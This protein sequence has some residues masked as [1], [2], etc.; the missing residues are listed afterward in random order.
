MS[1]FIHISNSHIWGERLLIAY[2]SILLQAAVTINIHIFFDK[3]ILIY[4]YFY[5]CCHHHRHQSQ[6]DNKI[7][8]FFYFIFIVVFYFFCKNTKAFF[9]KEDIRSTTTKDKKWQLL[10][11]L[12][13]VC[14]SISV[15]KRHPEEH[16]CHNTM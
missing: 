2:I 3:Y 5:C 11:F 9:N 8:A 10:R 15:D 7:I 6:D 1:L 4:K 16:M 13:F 12:L 14:V